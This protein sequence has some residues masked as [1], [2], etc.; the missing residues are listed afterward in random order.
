MSCK[1][2]PE[3]PGC[4]SSLIGQKFVFLANQKQATETLLEL[5]QCRG[6]LLDLIVNF[7]HEHS[8]V[9]T[10]CHGVSEDGCI[11]VYP[12]IMDTLW[13]SAGKLLSALT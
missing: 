5:V 13:A 4:S 9:P 7:H 1:K 2:T 12:Y 8:I 11:M 6:A 10:S 3:S